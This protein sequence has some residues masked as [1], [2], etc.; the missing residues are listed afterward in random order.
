MC[1]VTSH[2]ASLIRADALNGN[3]LLCEAPLCLWYP[4][5]GEVW[6]C[7]SERRAEAMND[8]RDEGKKVF[9]QEAKKA[10]EPTPPAFPP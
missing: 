9:G 6:A 5:G 7:A 3:I 4:L 2:H 1:G 8:A 10:G